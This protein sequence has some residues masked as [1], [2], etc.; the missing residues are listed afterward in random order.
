MNGMKHEPVGQMVGGQTEY[1]EHT[2]R[3]Y[4]SPCRTPRLPRRTWKETRPKLQEKS[5]DSNAEE[6]MYQFMVSS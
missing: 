6:S 3:D 4:M 5:E 1:F 2:R